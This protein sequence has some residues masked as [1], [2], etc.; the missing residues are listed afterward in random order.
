[1]SKT[2]DIT[3]HSFADT[4]KLFFDT[5][6]WLYLYGPQGAPN[7]RKTQ[8]YSNALAKAVRA[9]SQIWL[10]V[11]VVSEF[12][13]RFARMEYDIH[14]PD[15]T[16]R[17]EFKQFRNHPDFQ[18][19]SRAIVAT[20]R[21]ILKFATRIESGFSDIDINALLTEFET[22]PN[23]FNDQVLACLCKNNSLML[24]THDL[25]FKSKGVDILTANSRILN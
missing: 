22:I 18:P 11:L 5:N 14:F 20:V 13:N 4:D 16:R 6:I 25:D 21:N 8:I 24:V 23:D 19:I 10:D 3:V 12:V 17:P 15:R 1:M 2:I 9:K 7:D